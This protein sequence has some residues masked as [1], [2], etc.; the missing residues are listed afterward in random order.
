MSDDDDDVRALAARF[1]NYVEDPDQALALAR[2]VADA[3]E[4]VIEP[5]RAR[6][7]ALETRELIQR[8]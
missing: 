4:R 3:V 2:H 1:A 6:L 5:L 7:A 8:L